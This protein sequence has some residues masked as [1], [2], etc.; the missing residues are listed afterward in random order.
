MPSGICQFMQSLAVQVGSGK[1]M[2]SSPVPG[3]ASKP[4]GFEF[5]YARLVQVLSNQDPAW[6]SGMPTGVGRL[7]GPLGNT[8]YLSCAE[9]ECKPSYPILSVS[10]G[11][12]SGPASH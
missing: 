1:F 3:G 6:P 11:G 10:S 12:Q 2:Q 4:G 8:G 9:E 5:F 7:T